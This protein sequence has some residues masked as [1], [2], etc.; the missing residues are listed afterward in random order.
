MIRFLI[1]S[2]VLGLIY[3]MAAGALIWDVTVE[4]MVLFLDLE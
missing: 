1:S 3:Q 2:E 4:N